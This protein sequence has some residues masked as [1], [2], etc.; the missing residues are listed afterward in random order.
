MG[1]VRTT[2]HQPEPIAQSRLPSHLVPLACPAP[3]GRAV[4]L[5]FLMWEKK[6]LI[7]TEKFL[8][9]FGLYTVSRT[10]RTLVARGA[11]TAP[12]IY[13]AH[14]GADNKFVGAAF[15][16]SDDTDL[17][18]YR[19]ELGARDIDPADIP[20]GGRGVE[21]RD[22]ARDGD[23][24]ARGSHAAVQQPRATGADQPALANCD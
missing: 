9:D 15:A 7:P 13:V 6:S 17:G 2:L 20:G 1:K 18:R 8:H 10:D 21:I 5:A 11:G 16:M 22:P 19:R 23:A 4:E 24:V 14:Q 3:L 12:A